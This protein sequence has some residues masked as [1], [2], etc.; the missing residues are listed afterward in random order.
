MKNTMV[1]FQDPP[2][3][4]IPFVRSLPVIRDAEIANAAQFNERLKGLSRITSEEAMRGV[5]LNLT[6]ERLQAALAEAER[7]GEK[8][9]NSPTD[10]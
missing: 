3:Y 6:D 5:T 4:A 10:C 1:N 2:E 7:R 8:A 9:N